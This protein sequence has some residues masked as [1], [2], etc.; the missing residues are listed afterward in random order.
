MIEPD[1][2][3]DW[4]NKR[5]GS[6][7][8]FI[9]IGDK[10]DKTV[11]TLFDTYSAGVKTQ[12]DTWCFNRSRT[13]LE[14]NVSSLI[15]TYNRELEKARVA[16]EASEPAPV[17]LTDPK[18]INWSAN[19]HNSYKKGKALSIDEGVFVTSIYRPFCKEWLFYGRR[20]N[21]RVYLMPSLFPEDGRENLAIC[22]S[23][24]GHA[25]GFTV[26]MTDSIVELCVAAMKG[27]T[28]CF[29]LYIYD[30]ADTG[31]KDLFSD[32]AQ[33]TRRCGITTEGLR[34]FRAAYPGETITKEDIFY[35][36]YGLLHSKEYRKRY[37]D[38]LTKEL[39]R[40]P[41]VKKAKD[42][43]AFAQAG[44]DLADMHVNYESIEPYPVTFKQ[45]DRRTWVYDDA[46]AFFHVTRMKFAGTRPNLDKT[47]VVYNAN[48]TM[49]DIPLEAYDYVVNGKSALQW[50]IERQAVLK[51]SYNPKTRKGSDIVNDANCYAIETKGNPAYPLELFQRVITVS[52]ETMKIVR[53]LP[54]LDID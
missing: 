38:N 49:Q 30:D 35:Y 28:Q 48:I 54:K 15:G 11:E 16:E 27:G 1:E 8:Q 7:D 4:I 3:G 40:I 50:V 32:A 43:R 34:H 44:R 5:E 53:G 20:L 42:F 6:F 29:P 25:A 2:H 17:L 39:P 36:T 31:S 18:Q 23:A 24:P 37:A 9:K 46:E 33:T 12:R 45:G 14:C 51:N 19:L 10:K 52:L 22:V 13:G 21:E 47:T 41:C 26:L